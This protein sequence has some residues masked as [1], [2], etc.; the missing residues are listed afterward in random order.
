MNQWGKKGGRQVIWQRTPITKFLPYVFF[1]VNRLE[2]DFSS[3]EAH[4]QSFKAI[5]G[6]YLGPELYIFDKIFEFFLMTQS[7][8][9]TGIFI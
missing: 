8:E 1:H 6:S 9:G 4:L 5:R 2:S 7:L 3:S